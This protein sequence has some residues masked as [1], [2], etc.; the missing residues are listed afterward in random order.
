[1]ATTPRLDV[2]CKLLIRHTIVVAPL[3]FFAAWL[4]LAAPAAAQIYS[5]RDENGHLVLSDR[6]LGPVERTYTLP[7]AET[8]LVARPAA[9][10]RT[11]EYDDLIVENA[12]LHSIPVGL[13]RA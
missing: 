4:G 2:A 10:S 3:A 13:V 12:R 9:D 1:M 7:K 11:S 8:I 6:P 5:W